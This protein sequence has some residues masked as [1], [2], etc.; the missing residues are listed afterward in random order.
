MNRGCSEQG[1]R[2]GVDRGTHHQLEPPP[3]EDILA[4]YHRQMEEV[5]RRAEQPDW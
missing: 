5:R 1:D 4:G 2:E 3:L